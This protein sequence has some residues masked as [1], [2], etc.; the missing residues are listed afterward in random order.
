[1]LDNLL[2]VAAKARIAKDPAQ[3]VERRWRRLRRKCSRRLA[4]A[5]R[6]CTEE[7]SPP[8]GSGQGKGGLTMT[9]PID[10]PPQRGGGGPCEAWW[11]GHSWQ[12][13]RRPLRLAALATSPVT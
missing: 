12:P 5:V 8:L 9:L 3:H 2:L 6:P 11:R 10:P 13:R 4:Q 7:P 1:M